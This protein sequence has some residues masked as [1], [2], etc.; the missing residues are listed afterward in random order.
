MTLH[1]Y[2]AHILCYTYPIRDA[3]RREKLFLPVPFLQFKSEK[4]GKERELAKLGHVMDRE[5]DMVYN[6]F[7]G[8][9]SNNSC[10]ICRYNQRTFDFCANLAYS[11]EII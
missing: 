9:Q 4:G 5:P 3:L 11:S 8:K 10:I 1:A 7:T 2:V 6:F